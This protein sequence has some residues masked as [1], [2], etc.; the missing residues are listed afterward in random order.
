MSEADGTKRAVAYSSRTI[1]SGFSKMMPV[2]TGTPWFGLHIKSNFEKVAAT[3]LEAKGLEVYFPTFRSRRRWSDR[4]K[5][6]DQ[7]L[8]PGYLFCRFDPYNRLP[9]L[10]TPGVLSIVGVAKTPAPIEEDEIR[11]VRRIVNSGL[12]AR[13]WPFLQVGQRVLIEKGPLTGTEGI[14]LNFKNR[15]RIVVSISLLQ[16]SIAAEIDV[17]M[18]RAVHSPVRQ[19]L[20]SLN[21]AI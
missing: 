12:A 4:V 2:T 19:G 20:V 7:P 11:A 6:I 1:L 9:I 21:E 17:E 3:I 13:P 16:R 15:F 8:F 14:L 10:V 18:V 5:E